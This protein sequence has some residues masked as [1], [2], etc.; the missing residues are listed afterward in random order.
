M[1]R[2]FVIPSLVSW[3]LVGAA[4]SADAQRAIVLVRHAE[5]LDASEDTVLSREGEARAVALAALLKGSGVTHVITTEYRRTKATAAPL[6]RLM[7]LTPETVPAKQIDGL[8]ARLKDMPADAV[9]LVVGHSNSVPTMLS[10]LGSKTTVTLAEGDFDNAFVVVPR[11][12]GE[13]AVVRLKY[14]RPTTP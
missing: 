11:G 7:N 2:W 6:A 10:R 3:L 8:V 14:G 9:V 13:P 12:S 4:A 5:K 1:P